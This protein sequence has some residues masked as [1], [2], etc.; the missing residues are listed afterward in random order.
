MP[1]A[2]RMNSGNWRVRVYT[3]TDDTGKKIYKSFSAP[4][5]QEAEF[6]ATSFM[7]KRREHG[8]TMTIGTAVEQ[9]IDNRTAV[10]S[11]TTIHGYRR[12][13]KC[14]I[15]PIK[16][17]RICDLTSSDFQA[18]VNDLSKTKS[19]KTVSNVYG[20]LAAAIKQQAPD[21]A[22]SVRLPRRVKKLNRELPTSDDV[23]N[24]VTG[25][26]IELP[27]LIAMWLCLRM[28]EVRGITKSS[29][30]NGFLYI[31]KVK[32]VVGT[33]DVVKELAKTDSTRRA[34]KLPKILE[35][36]ILG[37][38]TE[39]IV[40][41]SAQALYARFV[42]IMS[43]HGFEGVRF[44]DLRHIAASDMNRLGIPDKVAAERGGWAT[45]HTMRAVYQHAFS[46]DRK[47]ADDIINT[48]YSK[49]L[50]DHE[51]DNHEEYDTKDDTA[52]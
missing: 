34:I 27:V 24:A 12:M 25:T 44:H 50:H 3:G 22:I 17:R 28:S 21:K 47:L 38:K 46:A 39:Y 6:L 32:V 33:H 43:K 52:F 7:L 18:F 11:P 13:L 31:D 41:I 35:N 26:S 37:S 15:T 4:T 1:K 10:L 45:T 40:T 42:K 49:L 20:L 36:M 51:H 19:P 29:V 5:K 14:N 16:D 23:I 8:T 48:Y 2:K 30:K 9:Y